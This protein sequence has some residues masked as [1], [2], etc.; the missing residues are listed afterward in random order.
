MKIII[1]LSLSSILLLSLFS[2]TTNSLADEN[3][4]E[5]QKVSNNV[6]ALVG[7]R[8]SMTERDLGANATF[9]VVVTRDSVVLIDNGGTLD[10]VSKVDQPKFKKLIGYEMLKGRNTNQIFQELERE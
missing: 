10:E 7:K 1:K 9:G 3:S 5:V 8:G 4:L 6:Y 2:V